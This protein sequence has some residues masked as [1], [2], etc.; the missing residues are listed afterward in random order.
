MGKE[1]IVI[2]DDICW[3]CGDVLGEK[4]ISR[5]HGIPQF[6]KPN[7]NVIIPVHQKCHD[8]INSQDISNLTAFTSHLVKDVERLI[9]KT[10]ALDNSVNKKLYSK[11][12][13]SH[14]SDRQN[15]EK[16]K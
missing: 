9:R 11:D 4:D 1:I 7:K 6:L 13:G 10:K 5:H 14:N 3:I 15:S 2:Y 8:I 12:L 16:S